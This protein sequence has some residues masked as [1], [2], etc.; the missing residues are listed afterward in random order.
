M[1]ALFNVRRPL[2]T[3]ALAAAATALV[4]G[5]AEDLGSGAAC[6][7]LCPEQTIPVRDTIIEAVVLD[8]TIAGYP[9]LGEAP[10]LLLASRGDTLQSRVVIRFDSLPARYTAVGSDTGLLISELDSAFVRI[11]LDSA[12]SKLPGTPVTVE[13]YAVD[14]A[15]TDTVTSAVA[16]LFRPDRLIGSQSFSAAELLDTA[17]ARIPL[18]SAAVLDRV[19]NGGRLRLGLLVR[20]AESAQLRA[21]ST[22]G[23][24]PSDTDIGPRLS[25]DATPADSGGVL[26]V[27]PL[28]RTPVE[29]PDIAANLTDY[30]FYTATPPAT[31]INALNVGGLPGRRT[32][33]RFDIPRSILDS[34]TVVRA[35]L[36]LTQRPNFSIDPRDTFAIYPQ[37]VFA[38]PG[39][40]DLSVA[41]DL[42]G[43]PPGSQNA[44]LQDSL[45]V[46]PADSGARSLEV[47]RLLLA[48]RIGRDTL[49]PR[50]LVLRSSVEGAA[51]L[52]A[53]FFSVEAPVADL[54]PRLRI[55]Y[56]PPIP[57]GLP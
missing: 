36:L 7:S 49:S 23:A 25:Y 11:R 45:R 21:F 8:T 28:S 6:P 26:T 40:T 9:S 31:E 10:Y 4:A 39:V 47:V 55:S 19:V 54:R 2:L 30:T 41:A 5:C 18:S 34:S 24:S 27:T 14:T 12:G 38:G 46:V 37:V 42:L 20:G 57:F 16:A 22:E 32:Y 1:P 35:T 50:A 48:W 17:G 29:R 33:L 44:L 15:A 51:A 13:A 56:I 52:Q 53:T 43:A 3:I